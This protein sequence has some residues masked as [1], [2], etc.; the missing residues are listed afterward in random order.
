MT[1]ELSQLGLGLPGVW[2]WSH[3]PLG[4]F[5]VQLPLR[6]SSGLFLAMCFVP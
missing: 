2:V 3:S 4:A 5:S 6:A 1:K